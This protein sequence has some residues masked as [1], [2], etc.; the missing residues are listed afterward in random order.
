MESDEGKGSKFW[1][2]FPC[3]AEIEK[4]EETEEIAEDILRIGYNPTLS[5]SQES[6]TND[7]QKKSI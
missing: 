6:C 3:E 1:A 5:T 7:V 2:W 4:Y